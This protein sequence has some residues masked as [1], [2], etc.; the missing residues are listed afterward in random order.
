MLKQLAGL[1][2]ATV[3]AASGPLLAGLEI[4]P[5]QGAGRVLDHQAGAATGQLPLQPGQP[6]AHRGGRG[7]RFPLALIAAAPGDQQVVAGREQGLQQHIAILVGGVGITE[8]TPLLQEVKA[9]PLPLTGKSSGIKPHQHNHPMGNGPHGLESTHREGP[10]A[11]AKTARIGRQALI[12]HRRH[13]GRPQLE[14]AG[15]CSLLPAIDGGQHQRQLPGL[16][17]TIAKQIQQHRAQQPSPAGRRHRPAQHGQP[18]V[19]AA[20]QVQPAAQQVEAVARGQ[21]SGLSRGQAGAGG[22]HQSEQQPVDRPAEAAAGQPTPLVGVA[23]PTEPRLLQHPVQR[24][25]LIATELKVP[26]QRGALQQRL[27]PGGG[28]AF[29]GQVEQL[30][31][32]ATDPGFALLA[33]VGEPPG[34]RHAGGLPIAKHRGHQGRQ[35]VHLGG[36]HQHVAGLEAGIGSQQL[37]N[38]IPHDLHLPQPPRTRMKLQGV[39]SPR[40][41]QRHRLSRIHQLLLQLGQQRRWPRDMPWPCP[42]LRRGGSEEKVLLLPLAQLAFTGAL[43]QLLKFGPQPTKACLQARGIEQPVPLQGLLKR[44]GVTE[45][46]AAVDTALPQITAGGK[47][48]QVHR[49]V[50]TDRLEQLHLNRRQRAE[51]KQPQTARQGPRRRRSLPQAL[52]RFQ[53]LEPKGLNAQAIPQQAQQQRLPTRLAPLS[54]RPAFPPAGGMPPGR[55]LLGAIEGVV[56]KGIGNGPAELPAGQIQLSGGSPPAPQPLA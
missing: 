48:V 23:P 44:Q 12:E 40:A 53:H 17:A 45:Q 43:E 8:L 13:H 35:G 33:A 49:R 36:H 54:P 1:Q 5:V 31:H 21:G 55:Q 46:A 39:I 41:L 10:T 56:V 34:Q 9:R 47:Q 29:A 16:V 15:G 37:Q 4:G 50:G 20:E 26:L 30:Q 14:L 11:V 27:E 32:G 24:R 3:A 2:Q 51:P 28:E 52:N 7:Q 22:Q 18:M 38:P 6:L 19:E 42:R 25:S